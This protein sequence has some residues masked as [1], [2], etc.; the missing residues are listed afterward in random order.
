MTPSYTLILI[1]GC[2]ISRRGD[3]VTRVAIWTR[4]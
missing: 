4:C 2:R 3:N 1:T